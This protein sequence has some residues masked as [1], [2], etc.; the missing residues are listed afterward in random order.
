MSVSQSTTTTTDL[1]AL[2]G[3][4]EIDPSHSSLEFAV[5]H[6]MV[7]TVRGRFT[8]FTGSLSL[9]GT[10]PER[11][12]ATVEVQLASVDTGSA[13]RD[14]HLRSADFFGTDE[15]PAMT[16]RSKRAERGGDENEYRLVGDLTIKGV[17]REV[18]LD[19]TY[20]G[21]AVDPWGNL[22][23]G[24]EG[25]TTINRKDWDLTWNVALEAGGF[26]VS[27]KIKIT[28]DISAT[29]AA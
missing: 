10:D 27:D 23:A 6:A 3:T 11:S 2:T 12:S 17:S 26:L 28:L 13:D 29:K 4:W 1:S 25:T 19:L 15:N 20:N 16:F 5:R 8:D 24:F 7:A 9:D 21:T 14:A 22:R 18:V